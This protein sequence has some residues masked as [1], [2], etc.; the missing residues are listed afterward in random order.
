MAKNNFEIEN[1]AINIIGTG[2]SIVG[3]ITSDGDIRIDGTLSGNLSTKGKVV[4]GTSG[5]I[6]G[7]VNCKN[8]DV[9]GKLEGKATIKELLTLKSSCKIIGDIT[10]NKIAI[11]P[12]AV[13]T[14]TCNM[15]GNT[16]INN[17]KPR[18][19]KEEKEQIVQTS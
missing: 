9:S 3:D 10:T 15:D 16:P 7:E 13:F 5:K 2:T 19:Q 18:E 14:G 6:K 17:V 11:E 8:S 4:I 1:K 12:G